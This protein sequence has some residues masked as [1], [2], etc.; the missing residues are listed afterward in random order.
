MPKGELVSISAVHRVSLSAG[1]LAGNRY[2]GYSGT[3]MATPHVAGVAAL[4]KSNWPNL[5][6]AQIK[7]TV[8]QPVDKKANLQDK[9][10]TGGV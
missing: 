5:D 8:L 10:A 1:T 7:A 9:T 3:S 4:I 2:G 6:D